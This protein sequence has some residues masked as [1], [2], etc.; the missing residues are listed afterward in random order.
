MAS[1]DHGSGSGGGDR[2][3]ALPVRVARSLW[4]RWRRLASPARERI[5]P[6]AAEVRDRA[7]ELR[8][9][10]QPERDGRDLEVASEQ[11]ADAMVDAA[12]ADPDV[13]PEEVGR[14]RDEL[15]R[16]LD[17]VAR[18]EITAYRGPARQTRRSDDRANLG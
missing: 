18:G 6:L 4:G 12:Q 8:G 1:S 14:L 16:E 13:S 7:L 10:D 5:G 3:G 2:A 11:L 9:S 17:R 15:S